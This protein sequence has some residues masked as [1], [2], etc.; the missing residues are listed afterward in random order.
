MNLYK[1]ELHAVLTRDFIRAVHTHSL[2]LQ[3]YAYLN[4]TIIPDEFFYSSL[5]RRRDFPGVESRLV[6]SYTYKK[7]LSHYKIWSGQSPELCQSNQ[8]VRTICQFNYKDLSNIEKSGRLFV[9]KMNE[10]Y[11][12]VGIDCWEEWFK[13]K[14][15]YHQDINPGQYIDQYPFTQR[16]TFIRNSRETTRKNEQLVN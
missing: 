16:T 12:L 10:E 7:L 14:E 6:E 4:G 13:V 1:G 8:Y 5:V 15:K 2:A 11:D 3:L 9:N